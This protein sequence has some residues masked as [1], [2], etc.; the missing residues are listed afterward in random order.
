MSEPVV[1]ASLSSNYFL[2]CSNYNAVSKESSLK[3]L[4]GYFKMP[5]FFY[6]KIFKGKDLRGFADPVID[7]IAFSFTCGLGP[8]KSCAEG[9]KPN[10][11]DRWEC[12]DAAF[13]PVLFRS[14]HKFTI[15]SQMI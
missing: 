5:F 1:R 11:A 15:V 14:S 7:F 8:G 2:D 10:R 3:A 9:W 12:F 6:S 4:F 13:A